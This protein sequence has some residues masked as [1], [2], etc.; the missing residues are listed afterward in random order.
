[1][2]ASNFL[3]TGPPVKLIRAVTAARCRVSCWKRLAA[4]SPQVL[5]ATTAA[6]RSF[7]SCAATSWLIPEP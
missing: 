5:R 6:T 7:G 1:M 2:V 3:S 4:R